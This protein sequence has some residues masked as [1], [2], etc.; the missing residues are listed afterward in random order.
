MS[1][2]DALIREAAA[3]RATGT[4]YVLA[5][6][7]SVRGSSYRRAGARML[8]AQDRWIAGCV[9]GG[10]LEGDVVRRGEYRI[11]PAQTRFSTGL[12]A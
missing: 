12:A 2:L 4:A 6:V 1:E 3:L 8:I 11:P 7:V 9:S 5:T 10:C